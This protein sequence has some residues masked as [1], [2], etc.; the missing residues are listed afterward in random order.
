M[1]SLDR[2]VTTQDGP[3]KI[4]FPKLLVMERKDTIRIQKP[5]VVVC[6]QLAK[7]VLGGGSSIYVSISY[8]CRRGLPVFVEIRNLVITFSDKRAETNVC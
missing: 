8:K 5:V 7:Q 2:I 3:V 6:A 1:S 4:A